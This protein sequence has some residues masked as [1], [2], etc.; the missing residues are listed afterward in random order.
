[1]VSLTYSPPPPQTASTAFP[2]TFPL[3]TGEVE[4]GNNK[5]NNENKKNQ[6]QTSAA[7]STSPIQP[8]F[9]VSS[10]M[11]GFVHRLL[12]LR[13]FPHLHGALRNA[14]VNAL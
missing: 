5:N 11:K 8:G 4:V 1:M 3:V 7:T 6:Q 12:A 13:R 2:R 14:F 9:P 10:R